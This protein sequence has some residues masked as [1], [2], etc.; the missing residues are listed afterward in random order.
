MVNINLVPREIKDKIAQAKRS[1]NVFSISLVVVILMIVLGILALAANNMLLKPN[2]EQVKNDIRKN[3]AEL[4][5]YQEMEKKALFLNERAKIASEIEQKR[6]VWSQIVQNLINCVPQQV[7]LSNVEVDIT[8][9][10]NFVIDGYAKDE[11]DIISFKDKL[12]ISEFFKDTNF[13]TATAEDKPQTTTTVPAP[14]PVAPAPT[15]QTTPTT[16]STTPTTE[17]PISQPT[18]QPTTV[19]VATPVTVTAPAEKR[20]NF[21]LEFN[22]EKYF[23][24]AGTK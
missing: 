5:V 14:A 15:T 1:A 24:T 10:P 23:V 16:T 12:E 3:S 17:Q 6:P 8:K 21:S 9:N 19:A 11:R 22:L 18:A 20:I 13:K 2:L 7:Q 4:A